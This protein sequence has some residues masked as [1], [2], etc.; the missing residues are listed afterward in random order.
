M[1]ADVQVWRSGVPALALAVVLAACGSSDAP[2]MTPPVPVTGPRTYVGKV[3][4]ADALIA[5]VVDQQA[6]VAYTC[7]RGEALATHT[8]WFFTEAEGTAAER[9]FH[10]AESAGGLTLTGVLG[11]T[12]ASGTLTLASGTQAGFSAELARPDSTAGLYQA[13]GAESLSGLIVTNDLQ[14]AG[15]TRLSSALAPTPVSGAITVNSSVLTAPPTGT[16]VVTLPASPLNPAPTTG[17]LPR[18]IVPTGIRRDGPVLVIMTHGMSHFIDTPPEV[19]DTPP[20]SRGEWGTDVLRGLLGAGEADQVTLFN[21]RGVTVSGDAFL[22]P[23][24]YPKYDENMAEASIAGDP[25]LP[26]HFITPVVPAAPISSLVVPP[27]P[28]PVMFFVTYRNS[29]G[30]LVE[31]GKRVANQAYLALR[32]YESRFKVTPGVIMLGHSFGNLTHR[33]M[34]SNPGPG[35]F[36]PSTPPLNPEAISVTAQDRARMEYLRDRTLYAVSLGGPHEGSPMADLNFGIQMALTQIALQPAANLTGNAQALLDALNLLDAVARQT[37]PAAQFVARARDGIAAFLHE[38]DSP[39]LRDARSS[40]WRVANTGPLHPGQARRSAASPIVG[41]ANILIPIYAIGARSPGGRVFDSPDLI[42]GVQRFDAV[43][44]KVQTW[45]TKNMFGADFEIKALGGGVGAVNKPLFTGFAGLLDRRGRVS[46]YRTFVRPLAENVLAQAPIFV[47]DAL[48]NSVDR[49][50]DTLT[51]VQFH[52]ID[53][54]IAIDRVWTLDLSGR[55]AL[56]VP[57]LQCRDGALSFEAVLDLGGLLQLLVAK[58]GSIHAS[59]AAIANLDINGL[60]ALLLAPQDLNATTSQWLLE[61][62]APLATASERCK[63]PT[64]PAEILSTPNILNWKLG[65]AISSFPAP[66]WKRTETPVSD[67]EIDSDGVVPFVSALGF[68]LGSEVPEFFDHRRNDGPNGQPGSWY[69]FYDSPVEVE[70]HAMQFQHLTG[71]FIHDA[72]LA[73][74]AGPV[75]RASNLS[76]F[77]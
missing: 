74:G 68:S 6:V 32:W 2:V 65:I 27:P 44:P 73:P 1:R 31:S 54:P 70:S 61:H 43:D 66:A 76:V 39:A 15:N 13:D 35:T 69:R 16:V 57:A 21:L 40:F 28:P 46:D 72:I 18:V 34:L 19:R 4:G 42:A 22:K 14:A 33:F 37:R 71:K 26:A 67:G 8:G 49:L 24:L 36:L 9:P 50:I 51:G 25:N 53:V 77:P 63:L 47:R 20:Y 30:G 45:T 75:P 55:L 64:S 5:L 7:G 17:T 38:L 52:S 41:A 23:E 56:P 62:A 29:L 60:L 12:T 3:S 11:A 59:L 10:A 48:D 58:F